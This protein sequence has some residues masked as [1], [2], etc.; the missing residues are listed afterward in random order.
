ME[1]PLAGV[2]IFLAA[3][4]LLYL[5]TAGADFGAGIL[6]LFVGRRRAEDQRQVITRAMAPVW[7]A[8]HVWLVLVITILFVA[9]PAVYALMSVHLFIPLTL[10]LMGIVARGCAF[11]FRHYDPPAPRA[12]R[13][14]TSLFALSSLWT[15]FFLGVVIGSVTLGEINP[16]ANTFAALYLAPW[17]N[18]FCVSTGLFAICLF[19]LLAA[20]YLVGETE[21]PK[22]A[23]R[24]RRR[25]AWSN[26][27]LVLL[28]GVVFL[29]AEGDGLP[30]FRL[31]FSNPVSVGSFALAS[32]LLFPFWRA[33][34]LNKQVFWTRAVGILIA[35]LVLCGWVA[36]Q[37]PAAIRMTGGLA[38]TFHDAAAPRA[39]L[40][41]LLMALVVGSI[42]IFPA[43]FYLL[44]IFKWHPVRRP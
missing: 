2:L 42:L 39:T 7:E 35:A 25:A 4:L 14:Y 40:R 19:A 20:V 26:G 34:L 3:A 23:S 9:F 28:G 36:V 22:L 10:I 43:L 6:E 5:L 17:I 38:L 11:T 24:F 31:F 21:D 29:T 15:T 44:Y 1:W 12:Y 8:N 30:L 41:A 18:R 27:L 13:I 32:L 37:Y 33:L 16:K